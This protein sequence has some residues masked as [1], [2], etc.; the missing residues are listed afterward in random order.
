MN[1]RQ[2]DL[3]WISPNESNGIES[4]YTHPHVVIHADSSNTVVV[5]ALTSNLKCA[6]EP[7]NVL[8]NEGEANLPRQSVVI[9]SQVS[10][11]DKNQP[12][13]HIGTLSKQR[14]KQVLAGMRFLQAM[15]QHHE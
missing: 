13:K 6:K 12:G 7:G 10:T 3:F 15:T 4:D 14:I 5:C 8:L 11:V 2:G 9:V 1:I